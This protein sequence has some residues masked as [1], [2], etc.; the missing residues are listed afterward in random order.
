LCR[1][2]AVADNGEILLLGGLVAGDTTTGTVLRFD[3]ASGT[4][5]T[6]GRLPVA[7]HDASGALLRGRAVVFGGGA[8][9]SVAAVQAWA[10]SSGSVVGHLR[11]GRSDSAAALVGPTAYVVGGFDGSGLVRAVE[12]TS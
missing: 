8:A 5:T 1:T 12:A 11:S 2:V 10:G 6:A 7:V 4:T 3:P 9:T